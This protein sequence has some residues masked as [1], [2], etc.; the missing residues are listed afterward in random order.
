M[1]TWQ[2]ILGPA[3]GGQTTALTTALAR[4]VTFKLTEPSEASFSI[5][6]RNT[7][8]AGIAELATDL[9][10]VRDGVLLY[11]GRIGPTSDSIDGTTH[12]VDVSA[13][14]Y[15]ELLNRRLM[16]STDQLIYS[17][18]DQ[19]VIAWNLVKATQSRPGGDLGIVQ[20][21]GAVS[22]ILVDRPDYAPGDNIGEAINNLAQA[23]NGFDWDITPADPTTLRLDMWHGDA[24]RG[25]DRGV[26]LEYGGNV[27]AVQRS[28][29]VDTYANAVR[30]NGANS[31]LVELRES[32]DLADKA[33]RP[34][35]RWE[36]SFGYT[37]LVRQADV[38]ARADWQ[39]AQSQVIVPSY[40][41][42]LAAGA[43]TGPA[44]IWLGDTVHLRVKSGRI[45]ADT[46]LRVYEIGVDIGAANEQ[47]Q[48]TL[49]A[50]QP[51][52][53]RRPAALARRLRDLEKR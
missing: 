23:V 31:T 22:G 37:D 32:P 34:E 21:A 15:R 33:A 19:A 10:V 42:T 49:A 14:D 47:V 11:R 44:Q 27:T 28:V 51:D 24:G 5:N 46:A 43:W 35:G 38:T 9:H 45:A 29:A 13:L 17:Q 52:F 40:T 2:Y 6:G 36:Q 18:T 26:Y 1:A 50:P 25:A 41:L 48:V 30:V 39:L 4:K 12:R 3:T 16:Y 53:R 20:G 8:A 7:E